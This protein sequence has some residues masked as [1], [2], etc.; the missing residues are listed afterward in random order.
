M[1]IRLSRRAVL[2]ASGAGAAIATVGAAPSAHAQQQPPAWQAQLTRIANGRT[3]EQGRVRIRVPEIAENGNTVPITV[4]V[5]GPMTAQDY[6]KTIHIVSDGNPN[7]EVMSVNF[8][9]RSGKAEVSTRMR[10]ARTSNVIVYA[11]T[12]DGKLHAGQAEAK[13]TIGGCGG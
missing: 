6:V 8:T 10:L 2:R 1:K 3:P 11:E 7:P 5:E 12:S 13:V 9:P 4:T